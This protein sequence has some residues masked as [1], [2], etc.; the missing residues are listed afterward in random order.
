MDAV[1]DA[2]RIGPIEMTRAAPSSDRAT[3][4]RPIAALQGPVRSIFGELILLHR[5]ASPEVPREAPTLTDVEELTRALRG[6]LLRHAE[7]PPPSVLSGHE[8]DGSPLS[9]AHAAFLALPDLSA[10]AAAISTMAITLPRD[11]AL[12]ELQAVLL[13]AARWEQ[14]GMRLLLGRL[15]AWQLTR[16]DAPAA[17][18]PAAPL[19]PHRWLGPSRHW[20]TVTPVALHNNPGDLTARSPVAAA[21]AARRA[22]EIVAR[23]CA[24]IC[25][26]PPARVRVMRRSLFPGIPTAPE[27]MPFPRKPSRPGSDKFQRVCVHAEL[28]FAE[29]VEGPVLIG[30]GRYLGMG[31][32]GA[33][34]T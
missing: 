9:G 22:A 26:P 4:V 11:V 18:D 24:H 14:S 29:G 33:L 16:V 20:G 13:A 31:I 17:V 8:P 21:R 2:S 34:D 28:E 3:T 1:P 15:G 30:A 25:L 12:D 32:C 23:A 19:D 7:D 10:C 5:T 6:A 27:F